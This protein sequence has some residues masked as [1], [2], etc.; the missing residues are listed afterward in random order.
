MLGRQDWFTVPRNV[1]YNVRVKR[2]DESWTH[3]AS[4][5]RVR[6]DS[7]FNPLR[8]RGRFLHVAVYDDT[9]LSQM[10]QITL[11]YRKLQFLSRLQNGIY[12]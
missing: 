5:H 11:N 2:V 1:V 10:V 7:L 4:A 9:C 12:E 3:E 6:P 8:Y